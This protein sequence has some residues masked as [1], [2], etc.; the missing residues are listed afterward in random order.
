MVCRFEEAT[1]RGRVFLEAK[2]KERMKGMT[3]EGNWSG[4]AGNEIILGL[5]SVCWI[6]C[7]IFK[8]L[9]REW[10]LVKRMTLI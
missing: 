4:D 8:D 3:S 1:W 2:I 10:W 7:S 9:R 6:G 5:L